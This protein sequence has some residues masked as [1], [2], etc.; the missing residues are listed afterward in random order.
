MRAGVVVVVAV[1]I[2][3]VSGCGEARHAPL[4][5]PTEAV[6]M[7]ERKGFTV[8]TL[9]PAP[10]G[11]AVLGKIKMI[12]EI[13]HGEPIAYLHKGGLY[14]MVVRGSSH[15]ERVP[16]ALW[17]RSGDTILIG[18]PSEPSGRGQFNALVEAL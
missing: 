7:L 11:G 16:D 4:R 14:V 6:R 2:A 10:P 12:F 9:P 13:G 3:T 15:T 1:V 5:D 17:H 8:P 18:W